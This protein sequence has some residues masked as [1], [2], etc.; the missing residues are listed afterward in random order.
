[1][2]SARRSV[3][4]GRSARQ[5]TTSAVTD[6]PAKCSTWNILLALFDRV[7][8]DACSHSQ[9]SRSGNGTPPFSLPFSTLAATTAVEL[10]IGLQLHTSH[11]CYWCL[12]GAHQTIDCRSPAP[13]SPGLP[14][15]G[16]NSAMIECERRGKDGTGSETP[17]TSS[18]RCSPSL[19]AGDLRRTNRSS[20]SLPRSVGSPSRTLPRP[21]RK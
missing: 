19:F 18:P 1:M 4:R 16:A 9:F 8:T 10:K 7:W 17:F 3:L 2:I 12:A 20:R 14:G 5:E 15:W 21:G 6:G 13:D 11:C